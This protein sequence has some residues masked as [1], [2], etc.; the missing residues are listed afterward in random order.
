MDE[1]E[2]YGY[3]FTKDGLKL[4]PDKI[5]AVKDCNPPES[6]EAVRS[7]L[8]MTGYLSKF[9]PRYSS[10]TA[11]LRELTRKDVKFKWGPQEMEAFNKLKNS[12]TSEDVM[13]YFDPRKPITV[14]CEASFHEG[15][16]S[17]L[18]QKTEKGNQPAHFISQTMTKTEK[19]Y[20]Q[21]EKDALI[22]HSLGKK[23]IRNVPIGSTQISDH[24][25]P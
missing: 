17:G 24:F 18:F 14:R 5:R 23:P 1:L 9:I 13:A 3:H 21:T 20:S 7:F 2:F 25:S 4:S 12:I 15:L 22:I 8:G 19:C 10:L 6:E 11:P 16:S